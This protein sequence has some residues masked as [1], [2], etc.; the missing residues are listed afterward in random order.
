MPPRDPLAVLSPREREVTQL[1]AAGASNEAIG[2]RL[3]LTENTVKTH[4]RSVLAK[5]G[6]PDR[7]QVVIWAY[8][9]GVVAPGDHPLG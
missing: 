5:L 9:N 4:V 1:L 8:E 7:I 2:R 3:Y 6:L